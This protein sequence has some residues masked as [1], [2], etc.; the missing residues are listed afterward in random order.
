[1][2][3]SLLILASAVPAWSQ[4]PEYG[5]PTG[6]ASKSLPP[7]L[8]E[9]VQPSG[10][11]CAILC[12]DLKTFQAWLLQKELR[13]ATGQCCAESGC[14][15]ATAVAA[16]PIRKTYSLADVCDDPAFGAWVAEMIPQVVQPGTWNKGEAPNRRVLSYFAPG[17]MLLVY[18][19]PAAH[20]EIDDLLRGM[21][22]SMPT[23]RATAKAPA[24][25]GLAQAG[26]SVPEM[27]PESVPSAPG[28]PIAAPAQHPRHLFHFIIR[29]EGDGIIDHNVAEFAK[30]YG[31]AASASETGAANNPPAAPVKSE[32]G[33]KAVPPAACCVSGVCSPPTA[34]AISHAPN[35]GSPGTG[36]VAVRGTPSPYHPV[37][38][39]T[40]TTED[41]ENE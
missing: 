21:K 6:P 19:T 15:E 12:K 26:Y 16:G 33:A 5:S 11:D 14:C 25:F 7:Q 40:P 35:S 28:Y 9:Q 36:P 37:P 32:T 24:H 23:T 39:T 31:A 3:G 41:D 10:G 17:K 2:A 38:A 29:Y 4:S 13:A 34:T 30:A 8:I 20:A 18:H 27:R 22:K 1:L